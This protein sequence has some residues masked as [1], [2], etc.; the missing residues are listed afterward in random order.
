[1]KKMLLCG[2][3]ALG[4]LGLG[5][6]GGD[7]KDKTENP[8]AETSDAGT[9]GQGGGGSSGTADASST[10]P[11]AGQSGDETGE[12][13]GYES[14]TSGSY[15]A[16]SFGDLSALDGENCTGNDI[17]EATYY[18]WGDDL[19]EAEIYADM[20]DTAGLWV[21]VNNGDDADTA[22]GVG[23]VGIGGTY[24][25]G[26]IHPEEDDDGVLFY[27]LDPDFYD[28]ISEEMLPAACVGIMTDE[29]AYEMF[30]GSLTIS[31]LSAT[32]FAGSVTDGYFLPWSS[33]SFDETTFEESWCYLP[34][35]SFSVDGTLE[36][37]ALE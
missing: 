3:A 12:L 4:L 13:E 10:G 5:A 23:T 32:R 34:P 8:P 14:C 37:A 9:S 36:A 21:D 19:W 15:A 33:V 30:S 28:S 24:A 1:M 11:D 17:A 29:D 6:C 18:D 20:G 31:S 22:I 16:Q 35:I 2:V 26:R 27:C 7:S 25:L